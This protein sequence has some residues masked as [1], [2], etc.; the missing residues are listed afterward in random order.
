MSSKI[1]T[2]VIEKIDKDNFPIYFKDPTGREFINFTENQMPV[3]ARIKSERTKA[4][5]INTI[6]AHKLGRLTSNAIDSIMEEM[7]AKAYTSGTVRKV[8]IRT[9]INKDK[10]VVIDLGGKGFCVIEN[11]NYRITTSTD[12]TFWRPNKMIALPSPEE[13]EIGDFLKI[14][15]SLFN[16]NVEE[17]YLLLLTYILKAYVTE[18][19]AHVILIIQGLQ[20]FG[21]TT[22]SNILRM[23]IDPTSP[24]LTSLASTLNDLLITAYSSHLLAFDNI[25][26]IN[27][28]SADFFCRLSTG[29]GVNKRAL[30]TDD[31]ERSYDISRPVLFNGIEEITGR[32]DFLD[33]AIIIML[34]KIHNTAR[35]S[36]VSLK[37]EFER[38]YPFLI[39]GIFKILALV[40]KELPS[41]R[42]KNLPRMSE[43]ARFGIALEKVLNLSEGTFLRVYEKNIKDKLDVAFSHDEMCCAILYKL[44]LIPSS[45]NVIKGTAT[46]II[47]K[48]QGN[49]AR[50]FK[51]FKIPNKAKGFS[52]HLSRI[53]PVLNSKGI[54]VERYRSG[55]ARL[56]TIKYSDEK[57]AEIQSTKSKKK[58]LEPDL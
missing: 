40:L 21:K 14:F 19:G 58:F 56:I 39:G 51:S 24:S 33:R 27:P 15:K 5:L 38:N 32:A 20:G 4:L 45:E 36:E 29:G 3:T 47:E 9:G 31:E 13:I 57:L 46:Q 54:V 17:E 18:S 52:A 28:E 16:L 26:Y 12:V 22:V 35:K 7:V 8:Y 2:A 37:E 55:D 53:E 34:K 10:Q 48:L 43:F 44:S 49:Q 41:V 25:S 1:I 50:G 23:L 11:G 30:Y 42:T 6:T